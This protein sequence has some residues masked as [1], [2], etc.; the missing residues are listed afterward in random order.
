MFYSLKGRRRSLKLS[1]QRGKLPKTGKGSGGRAKIFSFLYLR[2]WLRKLDESGFDAD[3]VSVHHWRVFW[4]FNGVAEGSK[5]H[6]KSCAS[7]VPLP[8]DTTGCT[9]L[10]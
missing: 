6:A 4:Q 7:A 9:S 5:S 1:K 8:G 10:L 2:N 3:L